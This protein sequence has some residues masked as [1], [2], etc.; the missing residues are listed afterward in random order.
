MLDARPRSIFRRATSLRGKIAAGYVAGFLF[1]LVI[2]AIL[3]ANLVAVERRVD[4][5]AV[6]SRFLDTTLEMRRYEKNWLLYQDPA[7]L[8]AALRYAGVAEELARGPDVRDEETARLLGA[9]V[10]VLR[11]ARDAEGYPPEPAVADVRD[12]GRRIT[13]VAERRS[14]AEAERVQALLAS[15]RRTLVVL[16]AIFLVGSALLA[17][18]V[19]ATAL[20]PLGE[21][22][23]GMQ[24]I[25]AG[26][27]ALLPES[28]AAGDEL[29]SMNA[30]FN[31]MIGELLEHREEVLRKER[32]ASLGTML[33][34]IAH[35][36]NNPLS[37]VSTSA[38][39]LEEQ[40]GELLP[41]ERRELAFHPLEELR[42]LLPVLLRCLLQT[43]SLGVDADEAIPDIDILAILQGLLV[44]D[45]GFI[46]KTLFLVE[47]AE[48]I[49]DVLILG[50]EPQSFPV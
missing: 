16:V 13:L 21:L 37:N 50:F 19:R 32:L 4:S 7:D 10:A 6:L 30:A 3:F 9:Y 40:D 39:L 5:S 28:P 26:E 49:V 1:L 2:A 23:R 29:A 33:A 38:E 46:L 18:L 47:H 25:A 15:S 43:A 36:L 41:G 17:R 20:R 45:D 22:Q 42:R 35:E 12:L 31:R 27:R 34:G 48:I 44:F 11:E 8:D 14:S 24:R